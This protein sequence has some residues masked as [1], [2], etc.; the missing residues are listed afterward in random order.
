MPFDAAGIVVN[1]ETPLMLFTAPW[2]KSNPPTAEPPID[3]VSPT[4]YPIPASTITIPEASMLPSVLFLV[5][6][7]DALDP[8][9][10]VVPP[11][12]AYV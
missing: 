7:K 9:P 12:P 10:P 5:I 11:T 2:V 8:V 1:V 6:L 3:T 4:V